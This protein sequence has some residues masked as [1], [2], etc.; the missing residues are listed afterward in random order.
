MRRIHLLCL[1]LLAGGLAFSQ[2]SARP[3][4]D[5]KYEHSGFTDR[6]YP[7]VFS[8]K[9]CVHS[10]WNFETAVGNY[11]DDCS[12]F[13]MTYQA[14]GGAATLVD[15]GTYPH[16]NGI[17]GTQGEAW[18]FDGSAYLERADT[19]D[20]DMDLTN[21]P[22][23]NFSFQFVVTPRDLSATGVIIQKYIFGGGRSYRILATNTGQI[24]LVVSNDGAGET[25][26][27]TGGAAIAL[28]RQSFVTVTYQYVGAANSIGTIYV[29][30]LATSQSAVQE[31]PIFDSAADFVIGA[32]NV[33]A[34]TYTGVIHDV[35]VYK[36]I[37][38][39]E[40]QHNEQF[41][42]WQGRKAQAGPA[43]LTAVTSASPP[44]TLA[45]PGMFIDN[46][47]NSIYIGSP[48][49]GSGGLYGAADLTSKWWR[50]SC[51]TCAA[52]DCT[53][54]TITENV[55][56]GAGTL[57]ADCDTTTSVH[58]STSILFTSDG[59]G[60]PK[61]AYADGACQVN[62]IGQ[63]VS[64][65]VYGITATGAASCSVQLLEYDTAVCGTLLAT[66]TVWGAGDP[67]A[68]W[69]EL[70]GTV[71]AAAWN[72]ATSS[73]LPR[74]RCD[75]TGA[76]YTV[77]FD[78][79][80]ALQSA[81]TYDSDAVCVTDA[82]ADA[83]CN[84]VLSSIATPINLRYTIEATVRSPIDGAVATPQRE[85]IRIPQTGGGG[86][87]Q[88]RMYWSG[89]TLYCIQEDSVGALFFSSV[90]MAGNAD[91][92]WDTRM[93]HDPT[94]GDIGCC[95][96]IST[97]TAWTCDATPASSITDDMNATTYVAGS[98]AAGGDIWV[99]DLRF[100]RRLRIGP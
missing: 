23:G 51:E 32:N 71:A 72:G 8:N 12:G 96:K 54:W 57:T 76:A 25:S 14:G 62:W 33:G 74:I 63:D 47:A 36:G 97:A 90:A 95:A 9:N 38:I 92:D 68:A 45:A 73:W 94:S 20:F 50:G 28:H 3:H 58:G 35:A 39:T 13:T 91:E 31:G 4:R 85:F 7:C 30:N 99:R 1:I 24:S 65:V 69:A 75:D 2:P 41:A 66:N 60:A 89:D 19:G 88:V 21:N 6:G 44:A 46:P 17:G 48:V 93:T 29:D 18:D 5:F 15:D 43:V 59:G 78:A 64:L 37:I 67:G 77:N 81:A 83:V 49:S 82:A 80:M 34:E 79:A 10:C 98:A 42:V 56:G 61:A 86:A 22:G 52:G 27:S 84:A 100:Y 55:G 70:S 40:A 11:N 26:M 16:A 53:G 87:N